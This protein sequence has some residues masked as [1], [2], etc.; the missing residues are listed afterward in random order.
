MALSTAPPASKRRLTIGV[1]MDG[2]LADFMGTAR[3]WF[4]N[5]YGKPT[6]DMIQTSWSAISLGITPDQESH[7]WDLV[8][9]KPGFWFSLAPLPNTSLIYRMTVEHDIYFVTN[10]FPT[11]GDDAGT[12]S[13]MWLREHFQ[14]KSPKVIVTGDKSVPAKR[15]QFDWFIDDKP[16]NLLDVLRGAP[17]CR[18]VLQD[19]TYNRDATGVP[20]VDNFNEFAKLILGADNASAPRA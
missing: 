5:L 4:F 10:R 17:H 9:A 7:F 1:D 20:R 15:Y 12:Q 18:L 3:K 14:I 19:G 11:G 16:S 13:N 8:R 6:P 2:V